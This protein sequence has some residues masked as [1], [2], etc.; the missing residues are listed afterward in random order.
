MLTDR[1][2]WSHVRESMRRER[3]LGDLL[4]SS[5]SARLSKRVAARDHGDGRDWEKAEGDLRRIEQSIRQLDPMDQD[6]W[7]QYQELEDRLVD[8]FTAA[9]VDF[10]PRAGG[11][12]SS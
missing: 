11:Y 8:R 12:L 10:R 6:F 2:V 9:G 5:Y 4:N 7:N 1:R 3:R